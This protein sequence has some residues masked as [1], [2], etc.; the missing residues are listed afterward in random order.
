MVT[1]TRAIE[2]MAGGRGSA[3]GLIL[4]QAAPVV[5]SEA[6]RGARPLPARWAGEA[7]R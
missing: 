5:D 4:Q 1:E 7:R 3:A 2:C 6:R